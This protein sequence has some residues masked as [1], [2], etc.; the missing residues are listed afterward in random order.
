M[1]EGKRSKKKIY[2]FLLIRL[3]LNHIYH[4]KIK[5]VKLGKKYVT[6]SVYRRKNW[7]KRSEKRKT[8]RRK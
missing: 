1:E 8:Y 5:N 4:L 3:K 6:K 2:R 7:S